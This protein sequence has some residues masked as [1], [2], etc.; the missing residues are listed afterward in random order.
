MRNSSPVNATLILRV[1]SNR[2][3][4]AS[5]TEKYQ[6]ELSRLLRYRLAVLDAALR[7]V[8]ESRCEAAQ[9]N[10]QIRSF[11]MYRAPSRCANW[12]AA[13]AKAL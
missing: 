9:A 13:S 1:T 8:E 3:G 5:I 2:D 12:A 6:H 11:G 4:E 10:M 7:R